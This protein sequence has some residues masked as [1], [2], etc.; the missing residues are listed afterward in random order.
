MGEAE[1][2]AIGLCI[3]CDALDDLVTREMLGVVQTAAG[4]M[5]VHFPTGVHQSLFLVRFLDFVSEKGTASLLGMKASCLDVLAHAASQRALAPGPGGDDLAQAAGALR[6]WLETIIDVDVWLP[7]AD[8]DV[9]LPVTRQLLLEVS[10]NQAKHNPA[11][12][13]GVSGKFQALLATAGHPLPIDA[14]PFVLNDLRE[15]LAGNLFLYYASWMAELLNEIRWAVQRYL[16]PLH[17]R[18]FRVLPDRDGAYTFDPPNS[19]GR[20]TPAQKWFHGLMQHV[21]T[22]PRL[23]RRPA[24][25]GLKTRSSLEG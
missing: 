20:G 23:P 7:S 9:Q 17:A 5:E 3:C 22:G 19:I 11:R 2:E 12:L 1:Q 21:H 16:D 15:H 24:P 8:L 4:E 10:G 25:A 18:A 14:I 13:S 6:T